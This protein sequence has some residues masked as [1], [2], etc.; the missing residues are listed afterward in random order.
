MSHCSICLEKSKNP[1]KSK[2]YHSFCNKCIM[3]WITQHDDCPL[4]RNPISDTPTIICFEE[5]DEPIFVIDI[6]NKALSLSKEETKDID[7]RLNDFIDNLNDSFC[8]YKWKESND[9]SW[10]TTIRK[11]QY[12]IEMNIEIIPA[13]SGLDMATEFD[14]YYIIYVELHKRAFVKHYECKYRKKQ[15]KLSKLRNTCYLFR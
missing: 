2:C 1:F 6:R 13:Q 12:C 14:N 4:C 3:E 5:E 8:L 7:N 11:Q 15:I 9:G 10:Y